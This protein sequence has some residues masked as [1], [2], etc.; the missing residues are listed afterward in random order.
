MEYIKKGFIYKP[1]G[2]HY[3]NDSYAC[4]ATSIDF[5]S[6]IRVY[7]ATRNSID[8]KG[9]F[10]S[11][12]SFIDCDKNDPSKVLYEHDKILLEVGQPGT[13][14][15]H[16]IMV[17]DVI[18][19]NKTYYMY[20]MGWQRRDSVPYV[21]TLGLATSTDGISFA[22]VSEGPVIGVS[23]FLPFGIG[24]VSILVENDI[25]HMWYTHY[26]NWIPTNK[27]FRPTYDIRYASSHN[28][29]DWQFGKKCLSPNENEAIATPCVRKINNQYHMWFAYRQDV[30]AMGNSGSYRIGY[31][32][33]DYKTEGWKRMDSMISLNLSEKGW[34]SEMLCAPDL[35]VTNK[36]IFLFYCGNNYGRDG[37]GYAELF[38]S[39]RGGLEN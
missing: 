9:H 17:A 29:M 19:H 3:W 7:F 26:N 32:V 27:G 13:F 6:F 38:I 33:S 2:K 18:E 14:D 11:F 28:G 39:N 20:Y 22:K 30:D 35:L 1:I 21:I 31:A 12:V 37:F 8:E 5:D 15:E 4:P 36:K 10:T 16:G 24:N 25:F 23:R 34:D